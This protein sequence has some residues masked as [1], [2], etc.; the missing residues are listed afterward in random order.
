MHPTVYRVGLAVIYA[1][2]GVIVS[3]AAY[4]AILMVLGR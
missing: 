4:A 2:D 1:I 3:V